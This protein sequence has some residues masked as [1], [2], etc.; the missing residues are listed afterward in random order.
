MRSTYWEKIEM[1]VLQI[2]SD[3]SADALYIYLSNKAVAYTRELDQ[4]IAIDFAEDGTPVGIDIQR[5]SERLL[6][7]STGGGHETSGRSF[8]PVIQLVPA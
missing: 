2:E 1:K 5:V 3:P 8:A 6:E 7:A 4:D